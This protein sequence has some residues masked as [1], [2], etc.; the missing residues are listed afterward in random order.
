MID[1][2]AIVVRNVVAFRIGY[3]LETK[4]FTFLGPAGLDKEATTIGIV[5]SLRSVS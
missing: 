2:R 4:N 1:F 5:M 3:V